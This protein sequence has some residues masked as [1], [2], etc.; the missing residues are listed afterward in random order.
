M[1]PSDRDLALVETYVRAHCQYVY[2]PDEWVKA[3]KESQKKNFSLF[4]QD[5][6]VP[7]MRNYFLQPKGSIDNKFGIRNAI[8]MKFSAENFNRINFQKHT[9]KFLNLITLKIRKREYH[10]KI[11]L[12][13]ISNKNI[14]H[15]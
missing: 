14:R 7:D 10:L 8:R 4:I 13:K 5:F 3:L 1:W 6:I 15:D 2:S 9:M 11:N 12:N